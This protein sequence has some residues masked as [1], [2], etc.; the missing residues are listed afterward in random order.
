MLKYLFQP[1]SLSD[2][3]KMILYFSHHYTYYI[4]ITVPWTI[5]AGPINAN[6]HSQRMWV[7]SLPCN[8]PQAGFDPLLAQTV[9]YWMRKLKLWR[10]KPPPHYKLKEKKQAFNSFPAPKFKLIPKNEEFQTQIFLSRKSYWG[11]G[12]LV[13][14]RTDIEGTFYAVEVGVRFCWA[15]QSHLEAHWVWMN[16]EVV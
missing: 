5:T 4:H 14:K 9:F 10:T 1:H 3:C 2:R 6:L 16:V 7:L 13:E 12:I 15:L 8:R 11:W